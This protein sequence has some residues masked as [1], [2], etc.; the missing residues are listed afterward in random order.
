MGG[1]VLSWR[2]LP[3][4]I[5]RRLLVPQ[6]PPPPEELTAVGPETAER[7]EEDRLAAQVQVTNWI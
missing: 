4:G 1:I 3:A 2:L 7:E 5:P 6:A